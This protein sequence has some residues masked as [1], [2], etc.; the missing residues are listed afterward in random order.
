MSDFCE[1][2]VGGT[3]SDTSDG[4]DDENEGESDSEVT[5]TKTFPSQN[6]LTQMIINLDEEL[7]ITTTYNLI[8]LDRY[9]AL[10]LFTD[11]MKCYYLCNLASLY[12]T[13]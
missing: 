5:K 13:L 8:I 1:T 6:P 11:F 4:D 10:I 2:V 3:F 12:N 7:D 9:V